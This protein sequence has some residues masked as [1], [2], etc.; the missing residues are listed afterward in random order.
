MLHVHPD[1]NR[2][3]FHSAKIATAR[4]ETQPDSASGVIEMTSL[5]RSELL[6]FGFVRKIPIFSI[7]AILICLVGCGRKPISS[8]PDPKQWFLETFAG[9]YLKVGQRDA[10]WDSDV[11][12]AI[13]NGTKQGLFPPNRGLSA[14]D[15]QTPIDAAY[16]AGCRDPMVLY[17]R[18]RA[19]ERIENI[20]AEDAMEQW[21]NV[22]GGLETSGYSSFHKYFGTVGAFQTAHAMGT[23][24]EALIQHFWHESI[25]NA[26][27]TIEKPTI[28]IEATFEIVTRFINVLSSSQRGRI[29]VAD[30]SQGFIENADPKKWQKHYLIGMLEMERAWDARG[31]APAQDTTAEQFAGFEMHMKKAETSLLLAWKLQPHVETAI[32]MMGVQLSRDN[33]RPEMENWFGKAMELDPDS[34]DAAYAKYHY[35]KPRWFG[36]RE[37]QHEFANECVRSPKWGGHVPLIMVDFYDDASES[38]RG[39]ARRDFFAQESVWNDIRDA[40]DKFF[41]KNPYASGWHQNYFWYAWV[42]KQW[43]VA[44]RELDLIEK[45][46]NYSYFGGENAFNEMVKQV[47][48]HIH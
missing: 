23:N 25:S 5:F 47:S 40:L 30:I 28:P 1:V 9:E 32:K 46:V 41:A 20:S 19:I 43:D 24:Q 10:R 48:E 2:L 22:A 45:P 15:W 16:D 27:S 8:S 18:L 17:L 44:K 34:Y 38:L 12:T 21:T 13:T 11:L 37:Q 35:L 6:E 7:L 3:N 26:E 29:N 31:G 42:A 36:T 14:L 33:S 4:N 39:K